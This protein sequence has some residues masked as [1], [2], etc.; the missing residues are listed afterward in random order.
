MPGHPADEP[1]PGDA[2]QCLLVWVE[3]RSGRVRVCGELDRI[4]AHLVR[5]V[6]ATLAATRHRLWEVDAS[7]ITFCDVEG[8]RVLVE[9]HSLAASRGLSMRLVGARP[10][11]RH[12]LEVL[13]VRDVLE[14][15]AMHGDAIASRAPGGGSCA[16]R[17]RTVRDGPARRDP[18][19]SSRARGHP[20]GT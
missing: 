4:S 16:P 6:L 15:P 10:F 7:E 12:L 13:G 18:E 3:L 9:G 11:L 14:A 20:W 8:L 17:P 1:S 5:D 2:A 19:S